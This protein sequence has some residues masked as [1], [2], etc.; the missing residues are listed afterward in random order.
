[1]MHRLETTQPRLKMQWNPSNFYQALFYT[2]QKSKKKE[3][4][5]AQN[6]V[7]MVQ[8]ALIAIFSS[9]CAPHKYLGP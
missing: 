5:L 6:F 8:S 3:N 4:V 1:M 7:E 2:G 9:F